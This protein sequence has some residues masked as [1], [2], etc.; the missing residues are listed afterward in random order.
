MTANQPIKLDLASEGV[1]IVK[2]DGDRSGTKGHYHIFVDK[3]PTPA[4]EA[5]P[6]KPEDN[7]ILHTADASIEVGPLAAGEHVLWVVLGDGA[8]YPFDPPVRAR[9]TVTVTPV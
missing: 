2:A 5:I 1:E 6:P 3:D 9:V 4:G 7:S 8:H